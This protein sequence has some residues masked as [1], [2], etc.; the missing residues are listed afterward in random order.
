M[1]EIL[2]DSVYTVHKKAYIVYTVSSARQYIHCTYDVYTV[3]VYTWGLTYA[4]GMQLE[5]GDI[6]IGN[7]RGQYSPHNII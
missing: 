7:A 2:R 1:S 4:Y 5:V 6:L 3:A